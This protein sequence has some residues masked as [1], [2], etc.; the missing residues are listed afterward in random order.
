MSLRV[1][2]VN[3]WGGFEKDSAFLVRVMRDIDPDCDVSLGYDSTKQYDLVISIMVPIKGSPYYADMTQVKGKKLCFTGESYD[4]ITTTPGC[5]AYIGFDYVEDMIGDY[6]YMRFPLYGLYHQDHLH[7]YGCSSFDELRTKFYVKDPIKKYSAVVSNPSNTL[8]TTLL[9]FLTQN[10][11]CNSG[12][13]VM[14]NL[15][16]AIGWEFDAKMNLTANCMYAITFEN[17][18]KRGYVTEK[19]YEGFMAGA[20]PYYWGTCDV[21]NEFNPKSYFVFDCS[22]QENINSSVKTMIDRLEDRKTFDE[23]R[24]IDPFVGFHSEKYIKDGWEIMK[25][26]IM[27]LLESQ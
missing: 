20:V 21:V 17:K 12:G 9:Q 2:F 7:R 14:N 4:L 22:T 16:A 27:N 25:S 23:M 19:I 8:R 1:A 6:K 26:F 11:L 24:S 15:G 3:L 13:S 10:N 5:D 18:I